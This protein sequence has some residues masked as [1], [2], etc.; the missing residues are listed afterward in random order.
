[1]FGYADRYQFLIHDRDS[2]FASQLDE[3]IRALGVRVLNRHEDGSRRFSRFQQP[4][5]PS[6]LLAAFLGMG[7]RLFGH[8]LVDEIAGT[9]RT[10]RRG[11]GCRLTRNWMS[12]LANLL[13]KPT[14]TFA[15]DV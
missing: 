1:M 9:A 7:W 14:G 11:L 5:S 3:S 6:G 10:G 4:W 15:L 13:A 2:I 8:F 12:Q